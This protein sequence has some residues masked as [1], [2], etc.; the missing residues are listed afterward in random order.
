MLAYG[1]TLRIGG[2]VGMGRHKSSTGSVGRHKE[3]PQNQREEREI[4][5]DQWPDYV[6][7]DVN[8]LRN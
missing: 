2:R 7:A 5:M 8:T 4:G 6:V 1:L 3:R